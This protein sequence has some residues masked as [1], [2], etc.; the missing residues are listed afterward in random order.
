MYAIYIPK[1]ITKIE[2][3]FIKISLKFDCL[4]NPTKNPKKNSAGIV[5]RPKINITTAPQKALPVL[6]AVI[7]KAYTKPQGKRPFNIPKR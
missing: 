3:I 1:I 5:L 7:A 2:A 4:K 6:A